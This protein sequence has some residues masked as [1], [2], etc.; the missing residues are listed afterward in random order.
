MNALSAG[1]CGAL[2]TNVLHEVLRRAVP[3]APRVDLL[4]MQ[5]LTRMIATRSEPPKGGSLY[6]ATLAADLLSNTAYFSLAG[7]VPRSKT[8]TAGV[9]LG[10]AAGI[11]AVALP[12]PLGL[13]ASTT[14]RTVTT[15]ALTIGLYVAGGLVTGSL[16]AALQHDAPSKADDAEAPD[17]P[18]RWNTSIDGFVW[19]PRMA[20]KA[21]MARAGRLGTYLMGHSPIDRALLKRLNVTTNEFMEIVDENADDALVL[22][23]LRRRGFDEAKVAKWSDTFATRYRDYIPLW[24]LDEGY[25]DASPVQRVGLAAFRPLEAP[26]MGLVRRLRPAP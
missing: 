15:K 11:G 17:R 7:L 12:R 2:T 8:V 10:I 14:S 24:D 1:A 22:A 13:D 26:L 21:R 18:R 16:L 19:I 23:A 25:V 9:V 4:G 3:D 6:A 5:A 20:D